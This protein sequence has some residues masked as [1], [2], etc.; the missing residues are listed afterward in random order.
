M[1]SKLAALRAAARANTAPKKRPMCAREHPQLGIW[2][3]EEG[4]R[5]CDLEMER[6]RHAAR[7]AARVASL[8]RAQKIADGLWGKEFGREPYR[9][10]GLDFQRIVE[11]QDFPVKV[12]DVLRIT[13]TSTGKVITYTIPKRSRGKR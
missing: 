6:E 5:L 12:P 2:R 3:P 4:C 10:N 7:E 11:P 8:E 9:N 13:E 1:L